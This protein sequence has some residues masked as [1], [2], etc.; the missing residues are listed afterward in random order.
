VEYETRFLTRKRPG[1]P[2]PLQSNKQATPVQNKSMMTMGSEEKR[3]GTFGPEAKRGNSTTIHTMGERLGEV[4][5][6]S[7]R[8]WMAF[9]TRMLL[10]MVMV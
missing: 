10:Q 9:V 8:I 3:R 2:S 5:S 6:C 4:C 7:S 1:N